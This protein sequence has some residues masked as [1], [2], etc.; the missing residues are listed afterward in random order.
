MLLL[1]VSRPEKRRDQFSLS[2]G[3]R[4]AG[5]LLVCVCV[6]VSGSRVGRGPER[7]KQ[8]LTGWTHGAAQGG[9]TRLHRDSA[10]AAGGWRRLVDQEQRESVC[11]LAPHGDTQYSERD[12]SSTDRGR[13]PTFQ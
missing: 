4:D 10:G 1:L 11:V 8:C 3:H 2:Y 13:R 12:S 9:L 6:R 5:G 7:V